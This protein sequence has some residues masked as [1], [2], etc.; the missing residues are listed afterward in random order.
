MLKTGGLKVKDLSR[1]H[2]RNIFENRMRRRDSPDSPK[3]LLDCLI[4]YKQF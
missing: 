4:A 1:I 2:H 3:R